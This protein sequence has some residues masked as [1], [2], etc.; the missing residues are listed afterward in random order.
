MKKTGQK[1]LQIHS[2]TYI[3]AEYSKLATAMRTIIQNDK[4]W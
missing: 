1:Q 4:D 2:H 3:I